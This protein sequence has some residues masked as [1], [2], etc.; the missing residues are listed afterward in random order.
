MSIFIMSIFIMNIFIY[1]GE[2]PVDIYL[3]FFISKVA[4]SASSNLLSLA[5]NYFKV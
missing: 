2:Q 1:K 3:N 4:F 5:I